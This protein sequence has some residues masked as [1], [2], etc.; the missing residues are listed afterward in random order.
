MTSG[1]LGEALLALSPEEQ[2]VALREVFKN[3]LYRTA[4][5]LL[6]YK[7]ITAF[8]HRETV[9]CLES[10]STRKLIVL[11]R[12]CFKSSLGSTS[13]PIWKLLRNPNERIFLD[14][15]LYSNSK[16]FL[17]EIKAHLESP[18]IVELF[19]TFRN[20]SCWNEGELLIRQRTKVYK[21]ASITA[22]GIGSEKTGQHYSLIICDDLNSPTNSATQEN[23]DKVIQ[24]YKYL[25]SILEPDGTLVVIGTRYAELD[26]PG[27]VLHNEVGEGELSDS[28]TKGNSQSVP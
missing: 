18:L 12:G 3:S 16:N 2:R 28:E 5:H 9:Q 20:D 8:T 24:H 26:I 6:G 27:F 11:P 23:R 13:Y 10:D 14:S 15:E 7:E 19:G 4:K 25:T 22:G 21:E 17:R 1:E